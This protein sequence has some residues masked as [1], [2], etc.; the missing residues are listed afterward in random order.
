MV[1]KKTRGVPRAKGVSKGRGKKVAGLGT[2]QP[3]YT[4]DSFLSGSFRGG[5]RRKAVDEAQ[6]LMYDAWEAPTRK[7]ALELCQKALEVSADC[8]DAYVMLA[9]KAHWL[10]EA[11][12]IYRRG[13]AAGERAIGKKAFKENVGHFWG[14]LET[15]P[16]MRAL[17]GLAMTL[18]E[19]RQREEAIE[20]FWELLRLNPNDN[21]GNR[22]LLMP[23]LIE[24]GRDEDAERLYKQYREGITAGWKYSRALLD[25][26]KH[27]DSAVSKKSL[28]Q[29]LKQ[30][31]HVPAFVLGR[32]KMPRYLPESFGFGDENEAIGYAF[33]D[34]AA[35]K[36]T[37]GALEWLAA[38]AKA[39]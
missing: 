2:A 29:A 5:G 36:A 30:N 7:R 34:K 15:R 14:I 6:A 28:R 3:V 24:L 8:A 32:K 39:K 21:Q 31:P 18:W 38:T 26:R 20:H 35:W 37:P 4:M 23:R 17:Q 11:V 13:V 9:Q 16:Y 27:G 12:A 25:F 10:Q 22:D 1:A 33:G 19:D